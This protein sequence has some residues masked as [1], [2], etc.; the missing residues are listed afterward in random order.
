MAHIIK[1]EVPGK[2]GKS[3]TVYAARWKQN[4]KQKEKSF[5]MKREAQAHAMEMQKVHEGTPLS[6]IEDKQLRNT[7]FEDLATDYLKELEDGYDGGDPLEGQTM[8]TYRRYYSNHILPYM[9]FA[10]KTV[11]GFQRTD[12]EAIR[13]RTL[14]A[15]LAP[16]SVR[17]V[18]RLTKAILAY[19]VTRGI[20]DA[21][22]GKDVTLKITRA[23]KAKDKKSKDEGVFTPAQ[24]A[25]IL[26]AADSLAT[27]KNRQIT[28]AWALYRPLAYLLVHTG[29]RISEARGFP[30]ASLDKA[31][32]LI[33]IRQRAAEDGEIGITKSADG[34]RDLPLH[35]D[36]IAPL[37]DAMRLS[38]FDLVFASSEGT[39]R[40]Y[41]NLYN[42]ML[43]PLIKR[44]NA[45][46]ESEG[47]AGVPVPMLGFHAMRHAY[48]ARLIAAG[49]NLKQLQVWM[50]HHDPAFTIKE[51]GHLFDDDGSTAAVMARM[52]I[53][54]RHDK[55]MISD[56][57][58]ATVS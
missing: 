37:E 34:M 42:R 39:P 19:G 12:M 3:R 54:P 41:H 20:I 11:G 1:K 56:S 25:A 9:Q 40:S 32:R 45:L 8:R 30:R 38:N 58:E 6:P 17:E 18:L 33:R 26:R 47:D 5:A 21:V 29:I 15:G 7:M 13:E 50:G 4:G 16:R 28:R 43:K 53:A 27:D 51:Y 48:A 46:A 36:L 24:I 49:A 14:L 57:D 10:G 22:P 23:E 52:T 35:P 2:K 44:A 55:N 31:A